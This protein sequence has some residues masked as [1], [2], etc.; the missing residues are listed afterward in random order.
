MP[1]ASVSVNGLSG[2]PCK[3]AAGCVAAA[4]FAVQAVS[5]RYV[6]T[7]PMPDLPAPCPIVLDLDAG[8]CL[9]ADAGKLVLGGFE[10]DAKCLDATQAAPLDPAGSRMR[11]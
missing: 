2:A 8:I 5:H 3:R 10:T 6:V 7:E 4:P 1:Q 9:E 11:G